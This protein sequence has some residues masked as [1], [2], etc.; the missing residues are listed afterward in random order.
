MTSFCESVKY[1]E[2][3]KKAPNTYSQIPFKDNIEFD[4]YELYIYD[5]NNE[6]YN[7]QETYV[8]LCYLISNQ[9]A[10]KKITNAC[11]SVSLI[12]AFIKGSWNKSFPQFWSMINREQEQQQKM[13]V[14][15]KSN[16][17]KIFG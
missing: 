12:P 6:Y 7:Q 14:I 16:C 1:W 8:T 15:R 10:F 5:N 2:R 9:N 13:K 4:P 17:F 3:I 11:C